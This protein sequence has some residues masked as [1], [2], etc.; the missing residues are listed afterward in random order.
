MKKLLKINEV[1]KKYNL[2]AKKSLGQ[3][4]IFD[5]N[6]TEKIV[7]A[8]GSIKNYNVLEIGSGP[9]SL[10]R[11]I[12]ESGAKNVL[13]IEIDERFL[14]PL[15]EIKEHYPDKL[16]IIID[17]YFNVKI[18]NYLSPPIKVISNLPYNRSVEMLDTLLLTEEWPP[19][20]DNLTLMFQKEVA[21]RILAKENNKNYGRL[22][23][24][25]NWRTTP[26]KLFNIDPLSFKP[27]PKVKSSLLNF[28]PKDN[29]LNVTDKKNFFKLIKIVFNQ[30]RKMIRKTL[31]PLAKD[32]DEILNKC[33]IKPTDRAENISIEKFCKLSNLIDEFNSS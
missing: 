14:S 18:S 33:G 3:N 25:S 16:N 31:K 9:G 22:S 15:N 17:D 23:I 26:K 27:H 32:I 28:K 11:S 2:S 21:D 30:R 5:L 19:F 6:L 8:S 29:F 10:T 4:Y 20:W 13:V 1:V 12:L 7:L 24:L